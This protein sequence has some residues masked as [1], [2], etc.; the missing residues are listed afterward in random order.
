MS[1]Q[2]SPGESEH[3]LDWR[4]NIVTSSHFLHL[5]EYD[6]HEHVVEHRDERS[7]L[8]TVI[9]LHNT[10][11]GPALG[12]C[13]MWPYTDRLEAI[14]DVLRLSR[15]MTYKSALAGLELGGGK[16]VIIGCPRRDKTP[17]LLRAMGRFVD[18][19]KG[20]YITA[21]DSGSNAADMCVIAEETPW[22]SGIDASAKHSG[23]PS[24][25]TAYGTLI[26]I[27]A[28][29]RHRFGHEDL[30]GLKV[31]IQG[32]GNVG[33]H[34]AQLLAERGVEL[35]V[36]DVSDRNIDRLLESSDAKVVDA[37]RIYDQAVD[38]F[39]PCAMGSAINPSTID[40]ISAPIIAGAA[41]N[42]VATPKEGHRLHKRNTLYVPDYAINAGGI[43]DIAYRQRGGSD[44]EIL[45][46]IQSIAKT[47]IDIFQRS[48]VQDRPTF[49]VADD[50][51]EERFHWGSTPAALEHVPGADNRRVHPPTSISIA[52]R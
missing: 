30:T 36:A 50:L 42:Q 8:H 27:Q 51:A 31:A 49:L 52:D 40:R 35:V 23:D 1:S 41:N 12:G 17:D 45:E 18:T 26:G 10:S 2:R 7:G 11:R 22:V 6:R 37:E 43:V 19:L 39:S 32:V 33:F 5:S 28:A 3:H 29:V 34:L 47:L 13:R 38:V 20:Q 16:A 15:G 25:S 24:P 46:H 14:R 21:P 48:D 9:A 4:K 44:A